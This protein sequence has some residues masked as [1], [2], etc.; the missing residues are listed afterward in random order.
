MLGDDMA[1]F[2]YI[3]RLP[4]RFLCGRLRDLAV[5]ARRRLCLYAYTK[6]AL[7]D[8]VTFSLG[9]PRNARHFAPGDY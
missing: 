6:N 4:S 5:G 8:S 1:V 3:V 9:R 7:R 2:A